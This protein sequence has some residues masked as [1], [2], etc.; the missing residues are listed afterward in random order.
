LPKNTAS[1]QAAK[2]SVTFNFELHYWVQLP[3]SVSQKD[4]FSGFD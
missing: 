3:G 2:D 4:R 1:W